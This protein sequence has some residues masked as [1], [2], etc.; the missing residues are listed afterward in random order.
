M[1]RIKFVKIILWGIIGLAASV[2]I[3]RFLTGLGATTNLSD[4][5]P[6]GLWVGFDVMG[7]VA[8]AA[9]GFVITA[10]VY[11]LNKEDLHCLARPA[12]LTAFLGYAAV[13]TGLMFDIG[14]PWNIWHPMVYWQHHSALFEVAWCVMLY[15]TVLALEFAPVP[16]ESTGYFAK[17]KKLLVKYRM[18][19]VAAGIM[20]STLHQSSLGTLFLLMPFRLHPLWYSAILPILFFVSA[21]GLGLLMICFESLVTSYLYR[22]A[23]ETHLLSKLSKAAI[24][25]LS[26]YFVI[27]LADIIIEGK[28]SMIFNGS[29]ESGLFIL[30]ILISAVIPVILLLIPSV[31]KSSGGLFIICLLGVGGFVLNRL[32]VGGITMLRVSDSGYFPAWTEFAISAGVVSGAALVFFFAIENFNVW[33]TRPKDPESEPHSS[34]SWKPSVQVWLGDPWTAALK[35][36]S[37]AFIVACACGFAIMSFDDLHGMGVESTPALKARGGEVLII[38]GNQDTFGVSFN[39]ELH[40]EKLGEKQSCELC[41]HYNKPY[42]KESGCYECHSDMYVAT[43][44]FNHDYHQSKLGGNQSCAECHPVD[45]SR[46]K[47]SAKDC[48]TCHKDNLDMDVPGSLIKV[49]GYIAVSYVDAMHGLCVS[50][51]KEI[52][53]KIGKPKHGVCTTC[54]KPETDAAREA[55]WEKR[56]KTLSNKWVI[57]TNLLP[58]TFDPEKYLKTLDSR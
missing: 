32:N 57:T 21:V 51:H 35:K 38:D 42:D 33:E 6:W 40:K 48:N 54:H 44:I 3:K 22:R 34:I 12:I 30:E 36:H 29:W 37:M 4:S 19:L 18:I 52:A 58:K 15:L 41:H 10:T 43:S 13:A 45:Q 16:L 55:E 39:H 27:R 31:R 28:F 9:G 5:V 53:E 56:Q 2:G 20:L 23:P 49:D 8:L 24:W 25:V 47:E 26:G 46:S 14:L 50:C 17:I 1:N 7:G 11:V